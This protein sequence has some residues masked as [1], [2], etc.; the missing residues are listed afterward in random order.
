[1]LQGL[2]TRPPPRIKNSC[3]ILLYRKGGTT[4]A[5]VQPAENQELS[6]HA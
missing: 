6:T 4:P 2:E 3:S 5:E 1:M